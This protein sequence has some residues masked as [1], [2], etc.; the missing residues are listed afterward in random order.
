MILHYQ[1]NLLELAEGIC[2]GS[3]RQGTDCDGLIR[4]LLKLWEPCVSLSSIVSLFTGVYS[5]C[6]ILHPSF[7]NFQ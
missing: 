3:E 6:N 5:I 7:S 1:K 2:Y 4:N